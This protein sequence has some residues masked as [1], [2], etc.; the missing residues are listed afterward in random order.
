MAGKPPTRQVVLDTALTVF[1]E[2]GVEGASI[3]DIRARS[4][5]SIGS[6]YHHFGSKQGLAAALYL[7]A[8]ASYQQ[9]TLA[10]L[11]DNPAA[12]DGVHA[13]VAAHLDW[14]ARN[15]GLARYLFMDRDAGVRQASKDALR[16]INNRWAGAALAWLQPRIAAGEIHDLPVEVLLSLW[17]G[18]AQELSRH[19][20]SR[21][22]PQRAAEYATVLGD[23]AWNSLRT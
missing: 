18:P 10:A 15:A 17:L 5:V 14:V 12:R 21:R 16:D 8:L 1:L 19:W 9:R 11:A 2:H 23:A 20:L 4:G 6:I 7:E 3:D 13:V 22:R